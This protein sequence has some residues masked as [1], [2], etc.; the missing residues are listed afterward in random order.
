[1]KL[2]K[3]ITWTHVD[4]QDYKK[5][6]KKKFLKEWHQ[7]QDKL[8]EWF[9]GTHDFH[10]GCFIHIEKPDVLG[11]GGGHP[12]TWLATRIFEDYPQV[13]DEYGVIRLWVSW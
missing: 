3:P 8:W 2:P 5:Y 13:A 9:C 7:H 11:Y 6:L 12:A 4:Y 10:N 1:M